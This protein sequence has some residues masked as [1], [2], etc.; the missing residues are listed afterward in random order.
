MPIRKQPQTEIYPVSFIYGELEALLF[1]LLGSCVR[2][3]GRYVLVSI[4]YRNARDI[5]G[6]IEELR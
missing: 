1:Y 4:L 6:I 5:R 3:Y 2:V